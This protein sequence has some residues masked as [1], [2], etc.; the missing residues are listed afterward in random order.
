MASK[1]FANTVA[2]AKS[3]S[4]LNQDKLSRLLDCET[5][6]DGLKILAELSYGDMS[7]ENPYDFE[8]LIDA[9]MKKH[10]EFISETSPDKNAT[11][12]FFCELDYH[13]LKCAFKAKYGKIKEYD[14]I[15]YSFS[16]IASDLLLE[17]V[18]NDEYKSFSKFMMK[19]CEE[20][21][22]AHIANSLTP[23]KIDYICDKQMY[24]E[25]FAK[26]K[27][28]SSSALNA[29]YTAKLDLINIQTM[30]RAKVYEI[31]S[32]E[33]ANM[34]FEGGSISVLKLKEQFELAFDAFMAEYTYSP[35]AE[36]I[37][38]LVKELSESSS[39]VEFE[40]MRDDYLMNIFKSKKFT[41][42]DADLF[43][44]YMVA[45]M[46]EFDNVRLIM[47]GLNNKLDKNKIKVRL[48][49]LYV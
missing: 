49:E 16:N 12:C 35:Y 5:G 33:L 45:K 46:S 44:A 17:S 25:I 13:N 2:V 8:I 37:K 48:K 11:D 31:D 41:S 43:Y 15:S 18:E 19:A 21:D 36:I 6:A 28:V 7:I 30:I 3:T 32:F 10:Y 9:E 23:S 27:K 47:V 1:T 34:I 14:K 42:V 39:Q 22:S 20:I 38:T 4:L 26:L 29:Y 24:A 40:K